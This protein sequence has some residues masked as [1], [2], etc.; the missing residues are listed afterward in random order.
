MLVSKLLHFN[1]DVPLTKLNCGHRVGSPLS[2]VNRRISKVL[3][4][5]GAKKTQ[6]RARIT[7]SDFLLCNLLFPARRILRASQ[8]WHGRPILD[9]TSS[10]KILLLCQVP[11]INMVSCI[12][13][14]TGELSSETAEGTQFL[15]VHC[16]SLRSNQESSDKSV[17]LSFP[18]KLLATNF[19]RVSSGFPPFVVGNLLSPQYNGFCFKVKLV[20]RRIFF[21]NFL[22]SYYFYLATSPCPKKLIEVV[23]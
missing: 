7:T 18:R 6:R 2:R 19:P 16:S 22:C 10:R 5:E 3:D 14:V 15:A 9:S 20:S 4:F 17:T 23:S 12:L 1:S 8:R 11:P 13:I 21:I